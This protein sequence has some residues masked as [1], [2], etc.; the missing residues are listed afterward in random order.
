MLEQPHPGHERR[1]CDTRFQL[2][3]STKMALLPSFR[4]S[5][6]RPLVATLDPVVGDAVILRERDASAV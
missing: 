2:E 6:S 4:R 3:V 5:D 1:A